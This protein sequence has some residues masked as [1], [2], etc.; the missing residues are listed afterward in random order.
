MYFIYVFW[1]E[2]GGVPRNHRDLNSGPSCFRHEG[3]LGNDSGFK[4]LDCCEC[5][6]LH[7]LLKNYKLEFKN[8][9]TTT[10]HSIK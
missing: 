9:K 1:A 8:I 5:V 4:T 3:K 2:L 7:I 6:I 10:I